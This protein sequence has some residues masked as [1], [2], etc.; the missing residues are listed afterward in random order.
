MAFA[1]QRY[2]GLGAPLSRGD[3]VPSFRLAASIWLRNARVFSK[4]WKGALRT[5]SLRG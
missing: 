1:E 5:S 4:L 2:A 3:L